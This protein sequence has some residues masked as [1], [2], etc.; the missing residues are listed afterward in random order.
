MRGVSAN[1][2]VVLAIAGWAGVSIQHAVAGDAN[3]TGEPELPAVAPSVYPSPAEPN[4]GPEN[5]SIRFVDT[6]PGETIGGVLNMGPAVDKEGNRI[7]DVAAGITMYMVHWGL[8]VGGAGVA[9]DAGAGDLGGD[10]M[11]F[12]DTGYVVKLSASD[13]GDMMAWEI[14]QGTVVPEDAVYFVGHTIYG[15]IHNLAKCTQTPIDNFV[16]G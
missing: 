6:D 8:E 1:D 16:E 2:F 12:R 15:D 9:D 11:G 13:A 10:C 4:Y 14:P 3:E 5:G 7:D